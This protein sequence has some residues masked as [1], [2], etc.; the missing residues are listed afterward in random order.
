MVKQRGSRVVRIPPI[1]TERGWMGHP[2]P[3]SHAVKML[4]V[5]LSQEMVSPGWEVTRPGL[6][7]YDKT[8]RQ[9]DL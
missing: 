1:R 3:H 9:E 5:R 4:W 2:Q 8:Y 6:S 7:E